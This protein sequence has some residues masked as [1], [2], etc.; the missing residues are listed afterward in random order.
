MG[1]LQSDRQGLYAAAVERG[2]W[3]EAERLAP[4]PGDAT[5]LESSVHGSCNPDD[6]A[7]HLYVFQ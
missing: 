3:G 1:G 6:A 4:A 2:D 7:Q 5:E